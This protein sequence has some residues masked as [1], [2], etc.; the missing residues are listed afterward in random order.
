MA[1]GTGRRL[2]EIA[3]WS[4]SSQQCISRAR[5]SHEKMN[6]NRAVFLDLNGTLVLP[7]KQETLDEMYLIPGADTAIRRLLA[8]LSRNSALV[9][10]DR[11]S[12]YI[13][14]DRPDLVVRS[15]VRVIDAVRAKTRL[16]P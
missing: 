2:L 8:A 10:A 9:Q 1:F 4:P 13:M 16:T 3:E 15:I 5:R 12:H 11:S 6:T 7:L 14:I